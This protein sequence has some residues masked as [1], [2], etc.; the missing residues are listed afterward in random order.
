MLCEKLPRSVG[1]IIVD[2]LKETTEY[3]LRTM[4]TSLEEEV[5]DVTD[6][7]SDDGLFYFILF[8]LCYNKLI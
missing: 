2:C 8:M 5:L 7:W 3:R 1:G 4:D 6:D